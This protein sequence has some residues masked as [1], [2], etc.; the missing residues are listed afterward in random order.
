MAAVNEQ[1][2]EAPAGQTQEADAFANLLKQS[3]KPRNDVAAREVENSVEAL[4][5]QALEDASIVSDDV[6]DTINKMIA[7]LDHKLSEQVNEIIHAPEFQQLE[8]AWRGLHY[9]IVISETD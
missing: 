6:L 2:R 4:V 8:S 9:L 7:S 3:F 5:Q 1:Q